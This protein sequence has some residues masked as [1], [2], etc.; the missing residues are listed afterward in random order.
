MILHDCVNPDTI[1][2]RTPDA[3]ET[4]VRTRLDRPVYQAIKSI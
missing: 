4:T 2:K 1:G 3:H